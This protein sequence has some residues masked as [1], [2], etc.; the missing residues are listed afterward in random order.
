M[1][2]YGPRPAAFSNRGEDRPFP[3]TLAWK[4]PS[5]HPVTVRPDPAD[6]LA[7]VAHESAYPE[8]CHTFKELD[9]IV[10]ARAFCGLYA[11]LAFKS[12]YSGLPVAYDQ[13]MGGWLPRSM[14]SPGDNPMFEVYLNSPMDTAP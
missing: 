10:A 14:K 6:R 12:L 3:L 7:A 5:I 11:V 9:S 13:L 8:I 1:G 2:L 4:A